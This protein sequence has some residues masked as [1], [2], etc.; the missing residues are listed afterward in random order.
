MEVSRAGVEPERRARTPA[1]ESKVDLGHLLLDWDNGVNVRFLDTSGKQEVL[2][3]MKPD[4]AD[5]PAILKVLR[6][7]RDRITP[8]IDAAQISEVRKLG[9]Q[10]IMYEEKVVSV[11]EGL[12]YFEALELLQDRA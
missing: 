12:Q 2:S 9:G 3:M 7:L 4:E 6:T 10:A 8:V 1:L 5:M 11:E